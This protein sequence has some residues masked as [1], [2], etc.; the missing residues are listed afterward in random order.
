MDAFNGRKARLGLR[1]KTYGVLKQSRQLHAHIHTV[2]HRPLLQH[3]LLHSGVV[4]PSV[5]L[6]V[7]FRATGRE[8]RINFTFGGNSSHQM[9]KVKGQVHTDLVNQRQFCYA[10]VYMNFSAALLR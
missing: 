1:R 3:V 6:S 4:R 10:S 7:T 5:R 2:L 9:F 8:G